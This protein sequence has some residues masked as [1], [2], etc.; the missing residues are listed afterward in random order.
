MRFFC[1]RIFLPIKR[2]GPPAGRG[3]GQKA[4]VFAC[5]FHPEKYRT[6]ILIHWHK[7]QNKWDRIQN[8]HILQLFKSQ[9]YS[10][11][12]VENPASPKL[13][14]LR[15]SLYSG[16]LYDMINQNRLTSRMDHF[17]GISFLSRNA[18]LWEERQY[19]RLCIL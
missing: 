19:G 8:Q 12:I 5:I 11:H 1:I 9:A 18:A 14:R 3:S 6:C 17:P 13:A 10:S 4:V 15:L 7:I 2:S 16:L